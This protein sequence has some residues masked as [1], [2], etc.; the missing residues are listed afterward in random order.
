MRDPSDSGI[1]MRDIM[2]S[3]TASVKTSMLVTDRRW[4]F[5][6]KAMQRRVFPKRDV[7]LMKKRIPTSATTKG[8]ER[9]AKVI[10]KCALVKLASIVL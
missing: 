3:L 4:L 8:V 5:L 2:M 1:A 6:K 10:G 9:L 7:M